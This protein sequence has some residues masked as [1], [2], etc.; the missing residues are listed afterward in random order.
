[1]LFNFRLQ[2]LIQA[3]FI[4]YQLNFLSY[5]KTQ[6]ISAWLSLIL[7]ARRVQLRGV[8]RKSV[9]VI[10]SASNTATSQAQTSL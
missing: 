9:V 2:S 5:E 7:A 8:R 1:V 6:D 4:Y 10:C 3:T